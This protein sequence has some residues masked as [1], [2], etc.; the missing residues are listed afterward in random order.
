LRLKGKHSS[1]FAGSISQEVKASFKTLTAG[2]SG[3]AMTVKKISDESTEPSVQLTLSTSE[4]SQPK[5][6]GDGGS[7]HQPEAPNPIA[8]AN[9]DRIVT[10]K[11][12]FLAQI[13]G[14]QV[15]LIPEQT[16]NVQVIYKCLS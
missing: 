1:L 11:P 16:P 4:T 13:N 8:P 3:V 15:L 14:Q 6:S 9:P 7:Q 12:A 5:S 10:T 2:V